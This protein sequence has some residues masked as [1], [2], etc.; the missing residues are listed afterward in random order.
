MNDGEE[1]GTVIHFSS[2]ND[3]GD[4]HFVLKHSSFLEAIVAP[5]PYRKPL[6][7]GQHAPSAA[8]RT[9]CTTPT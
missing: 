9:S 6:R 3:Y 1:D 2:L 5:V 4:E 8:R 7:L